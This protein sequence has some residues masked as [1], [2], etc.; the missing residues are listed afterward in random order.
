MISRVT[1]LFPDQITSESKNGLQLQVTSNE[2]KYS[3]FF[4]G[5][6]KAPNL[7]NQIMRSKVDSFHNF[8]YYPTC[9]KLRITHLSFADDPLLFAA[10]YKDTLE[11]FN[12]LSGLSVNQIKSEVFLFA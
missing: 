3:M 5:S 6:E 9:D 4:L 10:T 2:I 11:E 1:D 7:A 12:S 8:R